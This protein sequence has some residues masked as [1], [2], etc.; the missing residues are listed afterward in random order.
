MRT[1]PTGW[2]LGLALIAA[3]C[4]PL[5]VPPASQTDSQL[6]VGH[7]AGF[8]APDFTLP[9]LDGGVDGLANYRGRP[10]LINFWAS[11]CGPCR[12]EMPALVAAYDQ[13]R[14]AGLEVLAVNAADRDA[15]P[16]AEAF[17]LELGLPFPVLLDDEGETALAYVVRGLPA[18]IFVDADGVIR[19]VHTGPMTAEQIE[20]YLAQIVP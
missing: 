19:V 14:G 6:E 3:A 2:L 4:A 17:V 7:R 18:S 16:D 12:V 5:P 20:G 8:V 9:T 11:W 15:R 13:R 10:V 1:H